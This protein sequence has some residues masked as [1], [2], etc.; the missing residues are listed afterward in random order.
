MSI[1]LLEN[2]RLWQRFKPRAVPLFSIS[3]ISLWWTSLFLFPPPISLAN[4]FFENGGELSAREWTFSPLRRSV[5]PF[6]Q[7]GLPFACDPLLS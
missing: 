1:F 7:E 2:F 3:G 4:L 5:F 6:L